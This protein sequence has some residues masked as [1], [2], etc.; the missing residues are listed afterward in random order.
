ML[1]YFGMVSIYHIDRPYLN[2]IVVQT[3]SKP[4]QWVSWAVCEDGGKGSYSH[5]C[6][7]RPHSC[8]G[9]AASRRVRCPSPSQS[10]N[11]NLKSNL[12]NPKF[13]KSKTMY[14]NRW[15]DKPSTSTPRSFVC[16]GLLVLIALQSAYVGVSMLYE[17]TYECIGSARA[18]RG[19]AWFRPTRPI[20]HRA[21]AF[22]GLGSIMTD[23]IFFLFC[24]KKHIYIM[25]EYI[26]LKKNYVLL[27]R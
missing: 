16:M 12:T 24:H 5:P 20:V 4:L 9:S 14:L 7:F 2:E 26:K 6:D 15:P 13:A 23:F 11:Y 22:G 1:H 17:Y 3:R 25:I 19:L 27:A 8:E 21:W 10:N 18:A